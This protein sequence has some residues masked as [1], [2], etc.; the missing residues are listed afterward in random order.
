M[1]TSAAEED[2]SYVEEASNHPKGHLARARKVRDRYLWAVGKLEDEERM[3]AAYKM[4][5]EERAARAEKKDKRDE[6]REVRRKARRV[7]AETCWAK[8]QMR[9][10]REAYNRAKL[11]DRYDNA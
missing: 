8:K 1:P 4:I 11:Q 6:E 7:E 10:N 5:E 3:K 2:E 9:R